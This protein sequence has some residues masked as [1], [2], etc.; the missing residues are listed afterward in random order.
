MLLTSV[1]LEI[2]GKKGNNIT[3]STEFQTKPKVMMCVVV[4]FFCTTRLFLVQFYYDT[5]KSAMRRNFFVSVP[6]SILRAPIIKRP[7]SFFYHLMTKKKIIIKKYKN[8]KYWFALC[9]WARALLWCC[10]VSLVRFNENSQE[11][12]GIQNKICFKGANKLENLPL[13]THPIIW[14][15]LNKLKCKKSFKA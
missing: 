12:R 1:R 3:K 9:G 10:N 2:V 11:F 13:P 7:F 6:L 14:I 4:C 8:N 5:V 15:D